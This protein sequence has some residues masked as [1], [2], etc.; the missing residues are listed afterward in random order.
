MNGSGSDS[1]LAKSTKPRPSFADP[2]T[3]AAGT[4][5]DAVEK[6]A[7]WKSA[8]VEGPFI[9]LLYDR[10]LNF[11]PPG[12][13]QYFALQFL[14]R[15][16][17]KESYAYDTSGVFSRFEK[18]VLVNEAEFRLTDALYNVGSIVGGP[19]G[20]SLSTNYIKIL[21]SLIPAYEGVK[22]RKEREL[23]RSWLLTPT[24]KDE[25]AYTVDSR[26]IIPGLD[27]S[28]AKAL[29]KQT[30]I[31]INGDDS[32]AKGPEDATTSSDSA[33]DVLKG[34]VDDGKTGA[35]PMT[36]MEFSN[37][38]TMEY[39]NHKRDWELTRDSK[40]RNAE[41]MNDPK[42]MERLTREL[43]HTTGVE[44][45]KLSAKYSDAVVRG[46]SHTV[47]ELLGH[48]DVRTTAEMLQDAKDSLRESA[49]SSLFTASNVYPVQMQPADWFLALDTGFTRE[50]LSQ[51]PAML[52]AAIKAKSMQIDSLETQI[53]TLRSF[54]VG[55]AK[56][57]QAQVEEAAT[58]QNKAMENLAGAYTENTISA[59]KLAISAVAAANPAV[60]AAGA[61]YAAAKGLMDTSKLQEVLGPDSKNLDQ[62]GQGIDAVTYAGQGVNA[63]SRRLT[64]LMSAASLAKAGETQTM[65]ENT[66]RALTAAKKELQEMTENYTIA[67]QADLKR[68]ASPP[69]EGQIP[70]GN[71]GSRWIDLSI[72]TEVQSGTT[73]SS[74]QSSASASSMSCNFWIGSYS[75]SS[76]TS[77]ASNDSSQVSGKLQ[78]AVSMRVTYVT[79]DRSGWFDPSLA[80]MSAS[81]MH[82][83]E[84]AD[85]TSWS[86]YDHTDLDEKKST[87][88][89]VAEEITQGRT[90]RIKDESYLS[91]FPI[92]YVL[93][94]DCMIQVQSDELKDAQKKASFEKGCQSSGGFLCFSTSSS[95]SSSDDSST[96][97]SIRTEDGMIIRI[98]G[99]QI[100][101]YMMQLM[102]EDKSKEF[103]EMPTDYLFEEMRRIDADDRD[104]NTPAPA[105]G[106]QDPATLF[107]STQG[108]SKAVRGYSA[109]GM[110]R[111]DTDA[112]SSLE[113]S[114]KR[115][116]PLKAASINP[117]AGQ[118]ASP[119]SGG[120][121]I[122]NFAETFVK[123]VLD[124]SSMA[125]K[126]EQEKQDYLALIKD[127]LS[128]AM[129]V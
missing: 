36:R 18:P 64:E 128:A 20:Q 86:K 33:Q 72:R 11:L 49:V 14:T 113:G 45:A 98:P 48:L 87:A 43:A 21:N 116:S 62:I 29:S 102:P 75:S 100:L 61:T 109:G 27:P 59:V 111:E 51:D 10:L 26:L 31:Q 82:A 12:E 106:V 105:H 6:E 50:D 57:L 99:P 94:K 104:R 46:H 16:L 32:N 30:G 81:F 97:A 37:Q 120:K 22:A 42:E 114:D 52:E 122:G 84:G 78:I 44:N 101:G 40:I 28:D 69:V 17:D 19:N 124:H 77:S 5:T 95:S 55:D 25:A 66:Q 13:G 79:V 127:A 35:R 125:G 93:V 9:K 91:V 63:A 103:T 126:T 119:A 74:S 47:R 71:G 65:V 112:A 107:S 53:A 15:Y 67:V 2:S 68:K 110:F 121:T 92:G 34:V 117:G 88:A 85:Y 118:D 39:L 76:H 1:H 54:Q 7:S 73:T 96:A 70:A 56:A 4:T 8:A 24:H 3:A 41:D 60:A 83:Y 38:L 123:S 115:A 23:M 90:G 108:K 80:Q 89:Q 58:A 129:S